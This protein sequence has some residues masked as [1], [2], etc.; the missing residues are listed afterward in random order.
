MKGLNIRAYNWFIIKHPKNWSRSHFKDTAKCDILLNNLCESFNR[1]IVHARDQP[2]ITMLELIRRY[3]RKRM[4]A[5]RVMVD[6]W[7]H[8]VGPRVLKIIEKNKQHSV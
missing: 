5:R 3:I 8:E 4:V 6:K 7:H 1:A 2:I